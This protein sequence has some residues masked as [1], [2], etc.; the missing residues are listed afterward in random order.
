MN[1]YIYNQERQACE[2]RVSFCRIDRPGVFESSQEC[3]NTCELPL[4]PTLA[5]PTTEPRTTRPHP[6]TPPTTTMTDSTTGSLGSGTSE[7]LSSTSDESTSEMEERDLTTTQPAATE[8]RTSTTLQL[9]RTTEREA[10]PTT[11]NLHFET[12]ET[13]TTITT[14]DND[15]SGST[16]SDGVSFSIF[17]LSKFD[18]A[19]IGLGVLAFLLIF[20]LLVVVMLSLYRRH[21][22]LRRQKQEVM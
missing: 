14:K 10:P 9:P 4:T 12:T 1:Y 8:H 11:A 3:L 16:T 21:A 19:S 6:T 18:L 5:P 13:T 17:L 7:T 2:S 22:R 20:V 15:F